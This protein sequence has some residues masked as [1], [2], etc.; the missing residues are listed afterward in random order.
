MANTSSMSK[1]PALPAGNRSTPA[2]TQD[3]SNLGDKQRSPDQN[4]QSEKD[5]HRIRSQRSRPDLPPRSPPIAARRTNSLP[6]THQ[7]RTHPSTTTDCWHFETP[8]P[9]VTW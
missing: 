6:L 9:N 3:R 7:P 2:P 5:W 8:P 1:T 4:R